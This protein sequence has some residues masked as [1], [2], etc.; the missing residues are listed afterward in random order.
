[1]RSRTDLSANT[2]LPAESEG[3]KDDENMADSEEGSVDGMQPEERPQNGKLEQSMVGLF[4][5]MG[6]G[7]DDEEDEEEK[8]V[9]KF[10]FVEQNLDKF[11]ILEFIQTQ[12]NKVK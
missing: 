6:E 12:E 5:L 7:S 11:N 9:V 10:S 2:Q 3:Q 4:G 1:L 8:E